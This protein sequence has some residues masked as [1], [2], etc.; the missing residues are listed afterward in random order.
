M[1][2]LQVCKKFPYPVKDGEGVAVRALATGLREAGCT[3]DLLS[4][5]TSKHRVS[6]LRSVRLPH[7]R[8]IA[9]SDLDNDVVWWRAGLSVF[10]RG[11]YH[12]SR[13]DCD[14][15]RVQLRTMLQ[16]GNYDAVVL[17]TSILAIYIPEIRRHSDAAVV[18]RAHN[19]EHEIWARIAR[20]GAYPLR[21]AYHVFARRLKR[22]ER[23]WIGQTDL[24]MPIT[25]RDG[26]EFQRGLGY[27]GPLH[28]V[29]VGYDLAARPASADGEA[30][31]ELPFA[32]SFIGSLDWAPNREGL[33]WFLKE[34]W[35]LLHAEFPELEF[36]IAGRKSPPAIT[37]LKQAGVIVHG[38][39]D[40]SQVF[41]R[42]FPMTVAPILS[43]S[44]TRVK[45][46][47]AMALGRVVL[48]TQMGLEGIDAT[49]REE[50][51]ICRSPTAFLD[52]LRY[53]HRRRGELDRV[54]AAA[55]AFIAEH[56]DFARI[57]FG[58]ASR[59]RDLRAARAAAAERRRSDPAAK[60]DATLGSR[61]A[62]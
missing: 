17:E 22:F 11:S 8:S 43:G 55:R 26:R 31:S 12:V 51:M 54:G 24:L 27:K 44:G 15:F 30:L 13:F 36:H 41:L 58:V 45:I 23:E 21:P 56:F 19:L 29:P 7:Y 34:V 53:L 42:R 35:P 1:R 46:L 60:R 61:R 28:V 57:G 14:E 10:R 52:Q 16:V 20:R 2:I 4:F 59:I 33:M 47:D 48:T 37:N 9:S 18:L 3:V 49:D 50:V 40:D 5:N 62:R 39:V 38:E 25:A 32:I 6:D